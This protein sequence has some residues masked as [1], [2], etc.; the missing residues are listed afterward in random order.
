MRKGA[1]ALFI[2]VY[3]HR[4]EPGGRCSE[5]LDDALIEHG[6]GDFD[7]SGNVGTGN[8]IPAVSIFLCSLCALFVD[9]GHDLG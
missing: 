8:I 4:D 9:R 1:S 3:L 5:W 2:N 6:I 7:E